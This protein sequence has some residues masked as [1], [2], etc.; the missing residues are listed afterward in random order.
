MHITVIYIKHICIG[1]VYI[2][3]H[4]NKEYLEG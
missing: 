1:N 2:N 3:A 4:K